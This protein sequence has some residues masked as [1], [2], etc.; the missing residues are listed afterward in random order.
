MPEAPDVAFSKLSGGV[1][2]LGE[3]DLFNGKFT[4]EGIPEYGTYEKAKI[5]DG[6]GFSKVLRFNVTKVPQATW[7]MNFR[8]YP[9]YF[10]KGDYK[11][12]SIFLIKAKIRVVSG[13]DIDTKMGSFEISFLN[14][15]KREGGGRARGMASESWTTLYVPFQTNHKY[16]EGGVD[17]GFNPGIYNQVVEIGGFEIINYGTK[18][19]L[20]DMPSSYGS[21]E[22]CEE[23]AEWRKDALARIEKIR[24]GDIKVIVKDENGNVIPNADVKLD[25]YEHEFMISLAGSTSTS[26]NDWIWDKN[27]RNS[28]VENFNSLGSEG[29]LHRMYENQDEQP[30]YKEI[31]QIFK[32]A[33]ANGMGKAI[34]GHALMWDTEPGENIPNLPIYKNTKIGP[35]LSVLNDKVALDKKVKEHFEW[36][37]KNLT[38]ITYWDVTN[39]DSSRMATGMNTIKKVYGK[40]V[41]INWYKYA[42]E[43]IPYAKLLLTDGWSAPST[44]LWKET[45]GPFF[46]WACKNLDFDI[47]GHQGHTGY[48]TKPK[49]IVKTLDEL[50]KSGKPIHITEFDTGTIGEDQNYQGNLVR[51]ALIAYFACENVEYIQ[52]WGHRDWNSRTKTD[53]IMYEYDWTLKP[54]GKVFQDLF[55]NKWWTRETGKTNEN[56]E[57]ITKGYYGDYT[58]NV[59]ANGKTVSVDKPCYKG[60]DNTITI[61]LK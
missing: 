32:W 55:Y 30:S 22:G 19:K 1:K 13:G 12:D 17:I 34:K 50:S 21:Y 57:F 43:A 10:E 16:C 45:E 61:I 39:E 18:Y 7:Q 20:T 28:L 48:T 40:E 5:S 35:Y 27:Y 59:S 53:R 29:S 15:K 4:T 11:D 49:D 24:K 60:N 47:V 51:D 52:L 23:D 31:P 41:L 3:D 6:D 33:K 56:G 37:G 8:I 58:I 38:D 46:E 44:A 25:M 2:V 42:R 26:S 36:I 54:S 9:E 14:T